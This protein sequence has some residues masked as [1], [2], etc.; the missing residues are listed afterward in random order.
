[1]LPIL[2]LERNT[3]G[4]DFATGDLHGSKTNLMIALDR[5][6]FDFEKDRLIVTGDLIDRGPDSLETARLLNEPWFFS[7]AGNHDVN[8]ISLIV[9]NEGNIHH[10]W[11]NLWLASLSPEEMTELV[12]LVSQL[13][14]LIEVETG[15]GLVGV[16]H[17][18]PPASQ[19]SVIREMIERV[20]TVENF[21]KSPV[22]STLLFSRD[23]ISGAAEPVD[24]E[25]VVEVLVGHSAL[26]K[27]EVRGNMRYLDVGVGYESDILPFLYEL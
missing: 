13:P 26:Y 6:N 7:V 4:R 15:R 11:G 21:W 2:K 3:V 12:T 25:G 20:Y 14:Y 5:V 17:A 16:L 22:L 1:M 23:I 27:S 19:W 10:S 8:A 18:E 9:N 24:V